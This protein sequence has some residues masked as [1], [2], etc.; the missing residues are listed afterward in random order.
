MS[1]AT[2][3]LRLIAM[4]IPTVVAWWTL[5]P[6]AAAAPERIPKPGTGGDA[7]APVVPGEQKLRYGP[8]GEVTVY[9][10][11][12]NPRSVALFV[13]GDGG[14]NLGVVDMAR[15]LT[16]MDALVVGIDIRSYLK[17]VNTPASACRNFA[18]DFE[19]LAHEVE[20]R[21]KLPDYLPPVL[22]GYSSGATLVYATVVQS[23]KGTFGGAMSLGFCPDLAVTQPICKGSGLGFEVDYGKSP[24]PREARGVLFAAAGRNATPWAAFQGD[25]DQVCD[26]PGTRKFVASVGNA[27]LVWLPRVGHGFSVERNWLPQFRSA[28]ATLTARALPPPAT[29]PDVRDLPI[30]EVPATLQ[31]LAADRGLFAVLLTGDGGWAGLDQDVSAA[32]A[33]RGIPVVG[34]NTLKY[35]WNGRTPAAAAKDLERLIRRYGAAWQQPS[36]LLVGYS[37]GA[38]VLPFL[39]TRLPEDVR[40]KVRTVSLLGLSDSASFEFHV[41]DWIPGS[42]DGDRPVAPEV[43]RMGAVSVLCLYGADETDSPCPRLANATVAAVALSGGHH[44]DG[45]YA[46]IVRR[47][48]DYA[49][50]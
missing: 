6:A 4:A 9:R 15:H 1:A 41:S 12:A 19:G 13:S 18:V 49:H 21:A 28:Y 27:E 14:W 33:A 37:F 8:F 50:R 44:F 39:Y 11:H 38:D 46:S 16:D 10:P 31:P 32:L 24:A 26:P 25:M 2:R 45:D 43:A 34:L 5:G 48:V 17:A 20:R 3:W 36:V 29:L 7:P 35:F 42:D 23:P 40:A 22:V 47:I 30:V